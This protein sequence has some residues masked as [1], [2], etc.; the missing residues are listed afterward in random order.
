MACGIHVWEVGK[1]KAVWGDSVLEPKI[2]KSKY[3]T[4]FINSILNNGTVT[5]LRNSR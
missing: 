5:K 4:P 1:V 2:M 3:V